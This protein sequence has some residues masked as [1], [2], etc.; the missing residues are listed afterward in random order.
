MA[1]VRPSV[2]WFRP[3]LAAGCVLPLLQACGRSDLEDYLNY[4]GSIS[5]AGDGHSSAGNGAGGS[6]TTHGGASSTGATGTTGGS[7]VVH[8]GAT[9]I[10]G[11]PTGG[12]S[13]TGGV[14]EGGEGI[15]GTGVGGVGVAGSAPVAGA[16]GTGPTMS[17]GDSNCNSR[18]QSCCAGFGGFTCIAKGQACNGAT[19]GCTT[20]ADCSGNNVCC[21]ALTGDAAAASTCK[22]RCDTMGTGR[23]RQLCQ[24]DGDCLPPFRFCTETVFGVSICT[25]RP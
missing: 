21:I 16:A 4:D 19:L 7:G 12:A 20:N 11:S 6:G 10:A 24:V 5:Q 3:L 1:L 13:S 2:R 22:A 15:A 25:R 23:D 14:G 9:S 18:T 17:C 8:G